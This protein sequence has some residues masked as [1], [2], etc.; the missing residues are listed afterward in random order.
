MK[1]RNY[2]GVETRA[3]LWT[4]VCATS[5]K[6]E[7]RPNRFSQR[8]WKTLSM[9]L[10]LLLFRKKKNC[11]GCYIFIGSVT[12]LNCE[13]KWIRRFAGKEK[14]LS[15][16]RLKF[17]LVATAWCCCQRPEISEI[18]IKIDSSRGCAIFWNIA[19][20]ASI[21]WDFLQKKKKTC[22]AKYYRPQSRL[23]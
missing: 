21:E 3:L 7:Q 6:V 16:T 2:I 22:H 18:I 11:C 13:T 12:R 17:K 14:K 10:L 4:K 8:N 19:S 1:G 9:I 23:A 20:K 15:C 5:T